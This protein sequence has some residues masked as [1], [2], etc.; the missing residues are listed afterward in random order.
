VENGVTVAC[1]LSPHFKL[2]Q[3]TEKSDLEAR[4]RTLLVNKLREIS[5]VLLYLGF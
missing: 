3:T 4:V 2:T 1:F 5:I